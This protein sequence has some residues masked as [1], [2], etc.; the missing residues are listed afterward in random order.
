MAK[1]ITEKFEEMTLEL[2]GATAGQYAI[3]AGLI[4]VEV[5]RQAEVET[6]EI[7]DATDESLPLYKEKGVKSVEVSVSATGVWAQSSHKALMDWFYSGQTKN[8]RIG[9][10][11]AASGAPKYETGPALLTNLGHARE[12]G[13]RVSASI[14][15]EFDGTPTITNAT[16]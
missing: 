10:L 9:N 1:A 14:T 15:I 2:E 12:K 3:I 4:G 11:K 13:Q 6:V 7:P 8:I 5:T 16:P